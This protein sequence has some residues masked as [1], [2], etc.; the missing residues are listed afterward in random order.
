[1]NERL[2]NAVY[3]IQVDCR[4]P[5][6]AGSKGGVLRPGVLEAHQGE[7]AVRR[8]DLAAPGRLWAVPGGHSVRGAHHLLTGSLRGLVP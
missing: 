1:M 3:S 7:D 2:K 8:H 5:L 4:R 6:V